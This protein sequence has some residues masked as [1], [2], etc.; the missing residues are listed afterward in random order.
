MLAVASVAIIASAQTDPGVR[1]GPAGAGDALSSLTFTQKLFFNQGKDAFE[2]VDFVQNPPA[3]AGEDLGPRFNGESCVSC[4]AFPSTGGSSPA[5]NPQVLLATKM[6]A[7]NIVPPFITAGGPVREVR[8]IKKPDGTPDGGVHALFVIS[9]RSDAP[10]CNIK[11]EDFSNTANLSFRIPTPTFGTGLIEAIFDSTLRQNLDANGPAKAAMG[12]KGRLNVNGNDGTV[13]RFG[14]KAQN[15]SL[16]IFAG[17]AYNVEQGASNML[18]PQE[19]EEAPGCSYTGSFEDRIG[20]FGKLDDVTLFAGFM[21]FLDAPARGPINPAVTDGATLFNTVGC[22][23]CH[24][25]TLQTGASSVPALANRTA[26][27]YSDLALHHMGA[28]LADG[29]SQGIAGGDEF[30]TAPLWG[31]GK[32]IFFFHDG[33]AT[34]LLQV[35][36]AHAKPA[37]GPYPASEASAVVAK[38]NA[39]TTEQKQHL[40]NFLRSL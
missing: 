32:R 36:A 20:D 34:D 24:T 19:R 6:G 35:I 23:L 28:D 40:L 1:S 9:G 5:T 39:L 14:W 17:E 12:I 4:H 37:S 29:I 38:F 27:L 11:Q 15:K 22:T 8:F 25:P 33:R 13:T 2:E 31:L 18:F 30:R 10:G 21:R 7:K 3:N 26:D 16:H